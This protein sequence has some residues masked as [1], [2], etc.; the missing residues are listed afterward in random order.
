MPPT[1][2]HVKRPSTPNDLEMTVDSMQVSPRQPLPTSLASF[3]LS[4][5]STNSTPSSPS[6]SVMAIDDFS[7]PTNAPTSSAISSYP[8]YRKLRRSSLLSLHRDRLSET[9]YSRP[10]SRGGTQNSSSGSNSPN[11]IGTGIFSL[12]KDR[13]SSPLPLDRN[14]TEAEIK[15]EEEN[16]PNI[17]VRRPDSLAMTLDENEQTHN[18]VE[19]VRLSTP[20]PRLHS[21][22]NPSSS[23][24]S[25]VPRKPTVSTI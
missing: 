5:P 20:P 14:D 9:P 7:Y 10:Q 6:A 21:P 25:V 15:S 12:W 19:P 11:T 16:R 24:P 13:A 2:S 1:L 17:R 23:L 22:F 3:A 18:A 4:H 8:L